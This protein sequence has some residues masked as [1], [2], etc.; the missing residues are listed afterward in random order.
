MRVFGTD[1]LVVYLVVRRYGF[2]M[3]GSAEHVVVMSALLFH[4][5]GY[6]IKFGGVD[7]EPEFAVG[8]QTP[9]QLVLGM[10]EDSLL[11]RL[12]KKEKENCLLWGCDDGAVVSMI[13]CF[14][15]L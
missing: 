8:F 12:L 5:T 14:Y 7:D 2:V 13:R 15:L 1:N 11:H 4:G 9:D 10:T 6:H 3:E